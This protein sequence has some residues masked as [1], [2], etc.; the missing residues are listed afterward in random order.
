[1]G[2]KSIDINISSK[3]SGN[4]R[5][6]TLLRLF[7][8]TA[9]LILVFVSCPQPFNLTENLDGPDGIALT[10]S[11]ESSQVVIMGST[12]LTASG[13][14][15]PYIYSVNSGTGSINVSTGVYT[16]PAL[17]GTDI[18]QVT[19]SY[20]ANVT[21]SVG[22]ISGGG[23]VPL[24]ISPSAVS[25]N[26]G[27]TITFNTAGG[28][29]P[30]T[31]SLPTPI[32]GTGENITVGGTYTAP[33]DNTGDATARV[34][35]NIGNTADATISVIPGTPSVLSISPATITL[36]LNG[37]IDFSSS[38]GVPPYVYSL[39]TPLAGAGEDLTA[40][41]YTAPSD[42]TGN[43]TVRV[44]DNVGAVDDAVIT[45]TPASGLLISPVTITLNLSDSIDFSASG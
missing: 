44:T 1:M 2:K 23:P 9:V 12:T 17:T 32:T 33:S 39:F 16:A 29:P 11:P 38:G 21:A 34:T 15:P 20:G 26:G 41:T 31:Y 42:S 27:N 35:D 36:N 7:L 45:V 18:V 3:K 37:T 19:D 43:A 25:I 13:G 28:V 4:G 40:N 24:S 30:Y 6:T 14:V 22:I 10:L 8:L 5:S